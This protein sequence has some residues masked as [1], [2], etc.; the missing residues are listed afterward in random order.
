M[1]PK[2]QVMVPIQRSNDSE[3]KSYCSEVK[4]M[5]P[6]QQV[7]IPKQPVMIPKQ[8]VM[9]PKQNVLIPKQNGMIPKQQVMICGHHLGTYTIKFAAPLEGQ[10]GSPPP[11]GTFSL[12]EEFSKAMSLIGATRKLGAPLSVMYPW[13]IHNPA[14]SHMQCPKA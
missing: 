13:G 8:K 6:K 7:M 4:V 3:V 1:I 12:Q 2:Q 9:T 5:N 11:E 14:S 10:E